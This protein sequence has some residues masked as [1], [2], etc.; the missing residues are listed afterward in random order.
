MELKVKTKFNWHGKEYDAGDTI[1]PKSESERV[2]L[3]HNPNI[4]GSKKRVPNVP[5]TPEGNAPEGGAG[6]QSLVGKALD[7][8]KGLLPGGDAPEGNAPEGSVPEG[9]K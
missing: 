5:P 8:A 2:N 1:K 7:V 6:G 9:D 4:V 3:L